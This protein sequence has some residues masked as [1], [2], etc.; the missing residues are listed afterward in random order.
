MNFVVFRV[1]F[2]IF[3]QKPRVLTLSGLHPVRNLYQLTPERQMK[4]R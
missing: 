1:K 4:G 2:V 3:F